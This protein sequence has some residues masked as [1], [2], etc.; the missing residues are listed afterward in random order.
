MTASPP[1]GNSPLYPQGPRAKN[2]SPLA[3]EGEGRKKGSPSLGMGANALAQP[4]LEQ[5]PSHER[6]SGGGVLPLTGLRVLEFCDIWIG[7]TL[8]S[9]LGDMGAEVW[10]IEAI[11]RMSPSRGLHI[12]PPPSPTYPGQDPGERPWNRNSY[13]NTHSRSKY[14]FTLDLRQRRGRELFLRLAA[15]CD[16]VVENFA[17][18]VLNRLGAGYQELRRVQP[19]IVLLSLSPY[20][21]TGPY[22]GHVTYGFNI[23]AMCGH[24]SLR[25]YPG[26]HITQTAPAYPEDPGGVHAGLFA[27]MAALHHRRLTGEGQ[28]IDLSQA[29]AYMDRI[30]EFI[31]GYSMNGRVPERAGNRHAAMAP[32]GVYPC[33]AVPSKDSGLASLGGPQRP[34]DRW[35]A[36]AVASDDEWRR[37]RE[38]LGNPLWSAGP[39][40]E[41]LLGRRTH[42]EEMD[43]HLAEWTRHRDGRETVLLLQR[44]RVRCGLVMDARQLHEDPHLRARG[45]FERVTHPDA[46]THDY[47]GR[48]WKFSRTPVRIQRPPNALGEH[49]QL[50]YRDLLGL[51]QVEVAQLARD[52]LI[53]DRFITG[54]DH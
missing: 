35:I 31:L 6:G 11:H 30:G 27:L 12:N 44:R 25:G 3:G 49:N 17:A 53:G 22:R 33:K 26:G 20:G 34:Q 21:Q 29:E 16:A 19:D 48:G 43:R 1:P 15:Q 24:A 47:L 42:H 54:A 40:F 23:D 28:W 52:G 51:T 14:G 50:L 32:H 38:A 13:Y 41:T 46:G 7:P 10:K 36:I 5:R 45:Y 37:L 4:R 18:G 9:L 39:R 2:P 8:C